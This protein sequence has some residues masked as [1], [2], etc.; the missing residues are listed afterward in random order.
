MK[1]I[2]LLLPVLAVLLASCLKDDLDLASLTTNPLDLDYDGPPLVVIVSDTV[3]VMEG[4][5]GQPEDTVFTMRA[6]VRSE[7]LSPGT[8]WAWSVKNL[9]TG[10]VTSSAN[11]QSDFSV[12]VS[13]VVNGTTHCF[14]FTLVVMHSRTKSYT[15]CRTAEW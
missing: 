1:K 15:Y 9:Q 13:Q 3:V 6:H 14:A 8:F 2:L 12:F 5:Q 11:G 10:T 7:L 4:Q